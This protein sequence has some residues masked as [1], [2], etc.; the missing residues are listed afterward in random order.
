MSVG[1]A[2]RREYGW[3]RVLLSCC[4]EEG[5]GPLSGFVILGCGMLDEGTS[6]LLGG[7]LCP[8]A[9]GGWWEFVDTGLKSLLKQLKLCSKSST[10]PDLSMVVGVLECWSV[11]GRRHF[12]LLEGG[13]ATFLEAGKFVG[14]SLNHQELSAYSCQ[15]YSY[16]MFIFR[17]LDVG[18][19]SSFLLGGGIC[20]LCSIVPG[21]L[22]RCGLNH[23]DVAIAP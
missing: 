10:T 12:F 21:R 11:V 1:E 19:T 16:F 23:K 4:T 14:E 7:G 20:F 5:T 2:T 17:C 18:E 6:F 15:H 8:A 22:R 3:G 13:F 9:F